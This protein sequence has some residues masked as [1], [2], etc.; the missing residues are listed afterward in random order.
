M[1]NNRA[2]LE[3]LNDLYAFAYDVL[4]I[5]IIA[6]SLKIVKLLSSVK[7]CKIF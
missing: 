5:V 4:S 2:Y 1:L 6:K 7:A 3:D